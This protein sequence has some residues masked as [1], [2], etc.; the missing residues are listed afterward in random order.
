MNWNSVT[1]L[2]KKS[3]DGI[4]FGQSAH[5]E[6]PHY[7]FKSV[8]GNKKVVWRFFYIQISLPWT[9]YINTFDEMVKP[10][11]LFVMSKVMNTIVTFFS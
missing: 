5:A 7:C 1:G 4:G 2:H 11:K 6:P 10:F 3:K 8:T 9:S